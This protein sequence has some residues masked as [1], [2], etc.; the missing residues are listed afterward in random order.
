[1]P[2]QQEVK[3]SQLKVG[4]IVLVSIALLCTLLF[5][6]TSASGMSV[7]SHKTILYTYFQNSDGLKIGAAVNLEGVTIGEV[8]HVTVSTDPARKLTPVKVVMKIDPKYHA[9]VHTDSKASLSTVG[10]LGDTVVDINSVVATG[11]EV[12]TG[13]ELGTL[14][15]PNLT[16]V[17]KA[18]QGTIESLNVILA[19]VNN[20]VDGIQNGKGTVGKLINDPEMYNKATQTI[21]ELQKVVADLNAGKGSAG[22]L[23][24]DDELYNRLNDTSAKLQ[25]IT[26]DLNNG[27]GS[28]GKLLKDETLYN[29]LNS[30]LKHANSLLAEADAGKGA[31]GLLTK[32]PAFAKKLDGTVTQL[33]TLLT[34]VNS[35]RGTIGKLATDDT[36]YGNLN[37]LLTSSTDLVTAIRK[38][39]K[40][41]LVIHMKIF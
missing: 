8:T 27:K 31:L 17:V 18:S 38:D 21:D 16:D 32:D 36:L 9:S 22:K 39:P 40:K 24:H 13:S 23:L 30:T 11:P 37:T 6:M 1:M 7:F 33:D 41:Y 26:T 4:L 25:Q 29:N 14:Q 34:N 19:K 12:Q 3:W 28:A 15:T 2:S 5:L 10:V 35:G 20:I